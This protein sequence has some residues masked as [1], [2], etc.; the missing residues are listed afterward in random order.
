ME[1]MAK[2]P[3]MEYGK[4]EEGG[5]VWGPF[6]KQGKGSGDN[7][8]KDQALNLLVTTADRRGNRD[9]SPFRIEFCGSDYLLKAS[10]IGT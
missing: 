4:V 6:G 9:D 7:R 1:Q 10:K 2:R 5:S 8:G 3:R